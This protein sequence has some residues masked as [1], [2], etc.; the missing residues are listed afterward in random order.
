MARIPRPVTNGGPESPRSIP[1]V[2][3]YS[4]VETR[5]GLIRSRLVVFLALLALQARRGHPVGHPKHVRKAPK[6]RRHSSHSHVSHAAPKRHHG[7]G[8]HH[9]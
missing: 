6:P 8:G 4:G 3:R 7:G 5:R 9:K 2:S 1:E